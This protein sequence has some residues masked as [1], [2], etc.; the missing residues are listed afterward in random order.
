M[1]LDESIQVK[2]ISQN[3]YG[4]SPYSD[5]G[6]GATIQKVPDAPVNLQ[7]DPTTT[8]DTKVRFTWEEGPSN[9]SSVVLD[10]DVYYD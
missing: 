7:N 4:D 1:A 9:G 5:A 6:N 8:D 2:V 10:Y 3:V